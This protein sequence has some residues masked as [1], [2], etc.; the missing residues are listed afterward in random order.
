MKLV[1]LKCPNCSAIMKV[2]SDQ[3]EVACDYCGTKF[4]V[5]DEIHHI[6]YDNAEQAGYEFEK[7]RQRA[8]SE[9]YQGFVTNNASFRSASVTEKKNRIW[10]WVIG[11]I[12]M[13]PIPLTILMIRNKKINKWLRVGIIAVAWIV[14]IAIGLSGQTNGKTTQSVVD[15]PTETTVNE[16]QKTTDDTPKQIDMFVNC[17][18]DKSDVDLAFNE[19]FEVQDK[20]SGHYRTEFRLAAYNN[21]I[22]KSFKYNNI[23]IDLI[24]RESLTRDSI[25]RVYAV[26]GSLEECNKIIE[27]SAN[28]FDP[29]LTQTQ[30][31]E[32]TDYITENKSANGYYKG[33]LGILLQGNENSG[34]NLMIKCSND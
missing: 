6:Q 18:N 1:N 24:S 16:Q 30:I 25:L 8:Q 34:Y 32:I 10:L 29:Q 27:A 4:V 17:F 15:Q 22:G 13:F 33:S 14:Y 12:L 20:S 11:W 3:K 21:A 5:D 28:F 23:T 9:Q 2:N 26:G 31:N 7:G 19:D